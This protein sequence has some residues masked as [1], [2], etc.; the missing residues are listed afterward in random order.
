MPDLSFAGCPI[1]ARIIAPDRKKTVP[2]WEKVM[3]H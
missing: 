3:S 2:E 1:L